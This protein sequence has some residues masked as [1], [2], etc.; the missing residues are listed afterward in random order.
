MMGRLDIRLFVRGMEQMEETSNDATESG[1]KSVSVKVMVEVW[2]LAKIDDGVGGESD[3]DSWVEAGA[4]G[5]STR[6]NAKKSHDD[7]HC[8]TNALAVAGSVLT[9]DH[10]DDADED[11]SAD[12]L[13]DADIE[14]HIVVA[15]IIRLVKSTEGWVLWSKLRDDGIVIIKIA[16]IEESYGGKTTCN[17]GDHDQNHEKEVLCI[18]SK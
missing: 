12:G 16:N 3:A 4:K 9:L 18:F 2:L 7:N 6:D 10:Q 14:V 1:S 17:L 15:V 13:I 8:S 5:V 11:E